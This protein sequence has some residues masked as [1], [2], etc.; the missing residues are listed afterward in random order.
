[1]LSVDIRQT[2]GAFSLDVQFAS[3]AKVVALFGRSGSGKTSIVNAIAGV[4]RPAA[5]AIRIDDTVLFDQN[6]GIWVP[7]E[8]RR[9]GYVFQDGLL[10]P[11]HD[12]GEK[13]RL[14]PGFRRRRWGGQD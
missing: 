14:W 4:T 13:P 9:I 6:R 5:G 10:F 8:K 3:K 11:H 2:L 12:R 1:M 7:P